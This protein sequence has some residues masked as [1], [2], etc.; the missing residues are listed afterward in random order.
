M[1]GGDPKGHQGGGNQSAASATLAKGDAFGNRD[2]MAGKKSKISPFG[3]SRTGAKP[4]PV[5]LV[6]V[7]GVLLQVNGRP[8]REFNPAAGVAASF[9]DGWRGGSVG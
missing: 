2:A 4:E 7:V 9:R 6:G 3:G 8:V 1:R 5:G